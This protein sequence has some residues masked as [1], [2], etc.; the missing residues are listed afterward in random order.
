MKNN[1]VL[2]KHSEFCKCDSCVK[3]VLKW[4]KELPTKEGYYWLRYNDEC[5][6]IEIEDGHVNEFCDTN[7]LNVRNYSNCE[8]YGPIEPPKYP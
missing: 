6:V 7:S 2:T 1:I 4:T 5:G 8:W 3:P